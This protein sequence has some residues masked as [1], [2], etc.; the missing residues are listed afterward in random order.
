MSDKFLDFAPRPEDIRDDFRFNV[1]RSDSQA[2]RERSGRVARTLYTIVI[3]LGMD[4]DR[5]ELSH[6]QRQDTKSLTLPLLNFAKYYRACQ[7]PPGP[8][9]SPFFLHLRPFFPIFPVLKNKVQ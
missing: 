8:S 6:K 4:S 2:G 1:Q 9:R 7:A 5:Q 3:S